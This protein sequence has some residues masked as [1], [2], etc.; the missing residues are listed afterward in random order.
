MDL[1]SR[2]QQAI[3]NSVRRVR[4]QADNMEQVRRGTIHEWS[5]GATTVGP[6]PRNLNRRILKSLSKSST[7][8]DNPNIAFQRDLDEAD[9]EFSSNPSLP[10]LCLLV[11]ELVH[12]WEK[13]DMQSRRMN[14]SSSNS[15][16]ASIRS[17]SS[18]DRTV[19]QA[20]RRDDL[21]CMGCNRTGHLREACNF[22]TH[23][24]F[25][26]SG[27]WE[28]CKADRELR[29]RSVKERD[30]KLTWKNRTDGTRLSTALV[31]IPD[32]PTPP[33][34]N[35]VDEADPRR[36]RDRDRRDNG[37]GRGGRGGREDQ[38]NHGGREGR[39]HVHWGRDKGTPCLT[40]IITHLTCNCGG[41]DIN[42]TYRQCLISM[43]NSTTYFTALTLF[44]TGA[45]TSFVNYYAY[46]VYVTHNHSH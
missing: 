18:S 41:T 9:S 20:Q 8:R 46:T 36:R 43:R 10:R 12:R 42:S 37:S 31:A 38:G 44:N 1:G 24:D 14:G 40:S 11:A 5:G 21:Y 27:K 15:T 19:D 2:W 29:A 28:G 30:H 17:H 34:S 4:I 23:P 33:R 26:H 25:N 35:N 3:D 13:L 39:G 16:S 7:H 22:R 45:D 32:Q 6:I